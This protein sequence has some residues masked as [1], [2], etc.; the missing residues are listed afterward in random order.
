VQLHNPDRY[1]AAILSAETHIDLDRDVIQ[2]QSTV[3]VA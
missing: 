3:D 2:L 1:I